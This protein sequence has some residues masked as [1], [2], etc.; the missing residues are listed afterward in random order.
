MSD[1]P[2]PESPLHV[3]P[4]DGLRAIRDVFHAANFT[5]AGIAEVLDDPS[6]A[7][8]LDDPL[9]TAWRTRGTSPL[10]TLIRLFRAG[11]SVSR[12]QAEQAVAP[13]SLESW[14]DAGLLVGDGDE[15]RRAVALIPYRGLIVAT[16]SIR[17]SNAEELRSNHVLELSSPT[18]ILAEATVRLPVGSA[19]DLAAGSAVQ[20]MLAAQHSEHVVATDVNPRALN[21][22]RFN[23]VLNGLPNVEVRSGSMYEPVEHERFDLIVANPPYVISPDSQFVFRDSGMTSDRICELS[24]SGAAAHL[25]EGG[26][27]QTLCNWAHPSSGDWQSRIASWFEGS[28][29]DVWVLRNETV[30]AACYAC[31]WLRGTPNPTPE[32]FDRWMEYYREHDI[33]RISVG[34]IT[35]RRRSGGSNWIQ[36]DDAPPDTSGLR[37]EAIFRAFHF[38]AL[39]ASLPEPRGLLSMRLRVSPYVDMQQLCRSSGNGWDIHNVQLRG[40]QELGYT[41]KL[42]Q[43]ALTLLSRL[44]GKR[45][46]GDILVDLATEM[47]ADR[48]GFERQGIGIAREL[49]KMAFLWPADWVDTTV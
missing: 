7:A 36:F 9:L 19:L 45:P 42:D 21:M 47:K 6:E 2:L 29:C 20:G 26:F 31:L 23:A 48:D 10:E 24:V 34:L 38:R 16:D 18:R 1:A 41:G 3:L 15:V 12:K 27:C 14:M 13:T 37:G 32:T 22:A 11:L 35:M 44:D 28:N 4:N 8:V 5:K 39:L 46:L 33:E 25:N 17:R 43:I 49:L 30:D 40:R